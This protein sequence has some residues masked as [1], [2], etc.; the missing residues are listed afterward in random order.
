MSNENDAMEIPVAPSASSNKRVLLGCGIGCGLL[1]FVSIILVFLLIVLGNR[2]LN[3]MDVR[4]KPYLE[5]EYQV[6]KDGGVITPE[7]AAVYDALYDTVY[8][9]ELGSRW[10]TICVLFLMVL[11]TEDGEISESEIEHA[12]TLL[13]DIHAQPGLG[14][15]YWTKFMKTDEEL[16]RLSQTLPLLVRE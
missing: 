12:Q 14:M 2:A 15:E 4:S 16:K 7:Q 10:V 13:D 6:W 8:D 9:E 3:T 5:Q 1:V 11:H